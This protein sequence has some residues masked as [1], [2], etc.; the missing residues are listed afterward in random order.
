MY[1]FPHTPPC[2]VSPKLE[3]LAFGKGAFRRCPG[4]EGPEGA[5]F[6]KGTAL[7]QE[8]ALHVDSVRKLLPG[9]Q[10]V[11]EASKDTEPAKAL[12]TDSLGA[13]AMGNK[14]LLSL[15]QRLWCC[16]TVT[17]IAPNSVYTMLLHRSDF[18]IV[19]LG[20]FCSTCFY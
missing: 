13:T 16:I 17:R 9:I 2:S 10:E 3:V 19:N 15:R 5:A 14:F 20:H 6:V 11:C 8:P 12:I 7:P 18:T 4:A 1:V